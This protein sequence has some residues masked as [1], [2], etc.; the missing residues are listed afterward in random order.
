MLLLLLLVIAKDHFHLIAREDNNSF[1]L[2]IVGGLRVKNV[3]R[4]VYKCDETSKIA[5][6]SECAAKEPFPSPLSLS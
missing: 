2:K 6:A 5:L 3:L 4:N 1:V